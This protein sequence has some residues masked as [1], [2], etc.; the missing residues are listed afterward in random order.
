MEK[1]ILFIAGRRAD[2]NIHYGNP[3]EAMISTI[4]PLGI[5]SKTLNLTTEMLSHLCSLV[6]YSLLNG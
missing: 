3:Q 4:S 5:F 2:W 1:E 6:L